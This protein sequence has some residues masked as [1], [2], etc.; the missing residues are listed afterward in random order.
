M[1]ESYMTQAVLPVLAQLYQYFASIVRGSETNQ[2]SAID[3]SINQADDA[4]VLKLQS[5]RQGADR[6]TDP[7]GQTLQ[8]PIE[9]GAAAARVRP[10]VR[11]FH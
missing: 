6:R 5:L 11:Q 3:E 1:I 9:A 4:V 2:Q 7:L 8:R 10:G